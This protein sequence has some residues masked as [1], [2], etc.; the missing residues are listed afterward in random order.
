MGEE[1]AQRRLTAIL[2]AD[3]AGYSRLMGE[4]E[5]ATHSAYKTHLT[6]VFEPKISAYQ[7]HIVKST[8]DGFL[9]EFASVV[10]AVKCA[11]E[12]QMEMARKNTQTPKRHRLEFRIGINIGD[13]IIESKDIYGDGVNVAARI[14]SLAKPGGICISGKVY[15][16]VWNKV[17]IGFE[18]L[19]LRDVKNIAEPVRVYRIGLG[20]KP[21]ARTAAWGAHDGKR[22]PVIA[23]LILIIAASAI[24]ITWYFP[25]LP[26]W[27][28]YRGEPNSNGPTPIVE[29]PSLAVLPFANLSKEP[30]QDY[31]ADGITEDIITDLSRISGLFVI[32]RH[33]TFVYKD[34]PTNISTVK[35]DLG[36]KY[37]LEGSTRRVDNKV[38]INAQLVDADTGFHIWAG[39]YDRNLNDIFATQVEIAEKIVSAL[40]VKLTAQERA[41]TERTPTKNLDAYDVYLRGWADHRQNT[42]ADNRKAIEKFK[43]AIELD[44]QF[45]LAHA[46]LSATYLVARRGGWWDV[47]G[48]VSPQEGLVNQHKYDKERLDNAR[49]HLKVAMEKPMPLAHRVAAQIA[50]LD[51][52]H[53]QAIQQIVKAIALDPNDADSYADMSITLTWAGKSA[54][55]I[56]PI[57]KAMRLNPHFPPIYQTYLGIAEFSLGHYAESA[58]LLER[59]AARNPDNNWLLV[60]LVAAYGR[61]GQAEAARATLDKLSALMRRQNRP[62]YTVKEARRRMPYRYEEDLFRLLFGLHKAGM[63]NVLVA[64]EH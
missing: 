23:A 48:S 43:K 49:R 3:V 58:K 60:H 63:R 41:R 33:S 59:S 54:D 22:V 11:V 52:N 50:T 9:A 62:E 57:R 42:F 19:G 18:D 21:I 10:D 61:L 46:A 15:E 8:G 27:I 5:E 51:R 14:E 13:V 37:V 2:V 32:A 36:I 17:E 30:G 31:F 1:R 12:T 44:P 26:S 25:N 34:R 29:K 55:S 38:R 53:D 4:D 35:R 47:Q 28:P 6:T 24:T 45:A 7:G 16:E 39:R 64:T 20:G 40:A 56:E